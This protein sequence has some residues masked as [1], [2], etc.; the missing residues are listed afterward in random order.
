MFLFC[1]QL[2]GLAVVHA[3]RVD[4]FIF[5][6]SLLFILILIFIGDYNFRPMGPDVSVP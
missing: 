1:L 2:S 3:T 4:F 5:W 6:I